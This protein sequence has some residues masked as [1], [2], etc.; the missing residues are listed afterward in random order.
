LW[1]GGKRFGNG[2]MREKWK[3]E[4]KRCNTKVVVGSEI[5]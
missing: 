2:E 4:E 3:V 5:D 1:E